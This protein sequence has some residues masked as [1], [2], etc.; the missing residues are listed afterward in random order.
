MSN[1]QTELLQLH[2]E[3]RHRA[4]QLGLLNNLTREMTGSLSPQAIHD[5]VT[6]H[7]W[8]NFGYFSVES[9]VVDQ[10]GQRVVLAS[11]AGAY[12]DLIQP[13][14]YQQAFGQGL[15]GTAAATGQYILANQARQHSAFYYLRGA[16]VQSE[17]VIPIKTGKRL[18]ALLNVDSD[19]AEAFT[20][21][22]VMLLTTLGDQMA[23]ALENARLF[24]QVQTHAHQLEAQVEARTQELRQANQQ[25]RQEIQAREQAQQ[26]LQS[27]QV[28][29]KAQA[30]A[31][32]LINAIAETLHRTLNYDA[33]VERAI[34]ALI[35][36]ARFAAVG[37]FAL[38]PDGQSLELLAA[39]NFPA[40][41][42]EIGRKL[43]IA[44]SLAGEALRLREIVTTADMRYDPRLSPLLQQMAQQYDIRGAIAIPIFYQTEVLG[45]VHLLASVLP[46]LTPL[47]LRMLTAIGR[48]IGLAMS[49]ARYV[50]QI[51][52]EVRERRQIEAAWRESETRFRQ[53][54]DNANDLIFRFRFEP[55]GYEYIN[56]TL[57]RLTGYTPEEFYADPQLAFKIFHPDDK[58]ILD[59]F[60]RKEI[61]T[62][63]P[64][65]F[66][67]C[68]RDGSVRWMEQRFVP[69]LNSEGE[70]VVV[71][72]IGRD[73]SELQEK[74]LALQ[75]RPP[76]DL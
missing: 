34:N 56:P 13:G 70:I 37:I 74:L 66:R 41:L 1:P 36:Y 23:V 71:E 22:D 73:I 11:R 72:G 60:L 47:T 3:L 29:L 67:I 39:R 24:A 54:T 27:S 52:A 33:V 26:A 15:I 58:P 69:I 55:L 53:L 12:H 43:P 18:I 21:S 45:T 28:E 57:T 5:L 10:P 42:S 6:Q 32:G 17:L 75:T 46:T 49:N 64:V 14:E 61:R 59:A 38:L 31:L 76:V 20:D 65:Q 48:T 62:D 9:F 44:G 51:E 68:H 30:D 25:L 7:L 40:E 50:N 2:E 19:K 35:S 8:A 16:E 4:R 63:V